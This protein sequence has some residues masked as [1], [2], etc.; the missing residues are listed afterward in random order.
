MNQKIEITT[1]LAK[2]FG[3]P[4]DEHSIRDYVLQWWKNPRTKAN[5]GLRL[6]ED[7]FA[8]ASAHIKVHKVLIQEEVEYNNQLI[9][10]LDNFIECP[11]YLSNRAI[12]V[13]DEKI[14]VQLILFS[15]N[16]ARFTAAR[17]ESKKIHL[18]KQ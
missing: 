16:I 7:G 9:V 4:S 18:T 17:A 5:G 6:T 2:Q 12:F 14:A 3:L 1:Y 8:R 11:W 10:H 13:F 15:G